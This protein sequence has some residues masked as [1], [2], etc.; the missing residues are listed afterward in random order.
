MTA[1]EASRVPAVQPG[2]GRSADLG[3]GVGVVFELWGQDTGGQ[4]AVVEHPF[5][6]EA[7][8]PPAA[9][10]GSR[11]SSPTWPT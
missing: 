5:A 3:A 11:T 9:R 10:A 2:R 8:V 4:L 7:L 1:L 6:V